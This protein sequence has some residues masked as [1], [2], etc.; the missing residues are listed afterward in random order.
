LGEEELEAK[1][2][3]NQPVLGG[4]VRQRFQPD[5]NTIH[6]QPQQHRHLTLQLVWEE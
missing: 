5:W 1:L 3:G 4:A 2:F 6:Q